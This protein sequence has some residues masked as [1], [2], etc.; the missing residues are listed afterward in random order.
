VRHVPIL[1]PLLPVLREWRLRNPSD[2]V[3]PNRDGNQLLPS[4]RIFQE[5]LH[6]VLDAAG[7]ARPKTG[8]YLHEI[9]FHSLRHTFASHWVMNGG[10][11][12]R[13]QRILGHQNI[14]MTM[15]YAHLAPNAYDGDFGRLGGALVPAGGASV[16]P[17][18]PSAQHRVN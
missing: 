14:M 17:L 6:V 18:R 7:F 16:L 15:R 9:N 4:A 2:L 11:I 12:F 13:L 5:R 3:F 10:D 8:R 1:D